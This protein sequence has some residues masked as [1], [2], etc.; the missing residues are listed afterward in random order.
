MKPA[1]RQVEFSLLIATLVMVSIGTAPA[2]FTH[3]G[4][5]NAPW[6]DPKFFPI[7]VWL[8]VPENAARY[9]AAGINTYVGLWDG[10]KTGQ[11]EALQQ[12]GMFVICGQ[13]IRALERRNE[14]TII[15]WHQPDEPD[16]ARRRGA[17][18][19]WGQ[20]TPPAEIIA[21]Y[22]RLKR[23][24]PSRPV[25]L[26]LGQ[27]VAWDGWYGR[28]SRNNRPEDYPEYVQGGD[29]LSFNIYPVNHDRPEI[30]GNLW[31][32][33]E[34]VKRLR[35]W[36]GESKPVWNCI[37]TTR[38]ETIGRK[39]TPAEVRAQVWM[40]LIHGARGLIYFVHQFTP[41]FVEAGLLADAEM[42]AAV[43][44]INREITELAPVLNS[45]A[46]TN[47]V[48]VRA[49]NSAA[50][51]ATLTKQHGQFTYVF[52][53]AMRPLSTEVEF[54]GAIFRNVTTVEVIGESRTR[55]IAQG[56]FT[57]TFAPYEV[58]LYRIETPPAH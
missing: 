46:V 19:G 14:S 20:P 54:A 5:T 31:I 22:E 28:G 45:P 7:G 9:R 1:R 58:H 3:P 23:A 44:T 56:M 42:L 35:Q 41:T 12:A 50:P 57:D 53:V 36:A 52:A 25:L 2:Q 8:Q 26:G 39:P 17:R 51:I 32:V 49:R 13:T 40:S 33:A 16:N 43:T 21:A 38:I 34:G 11:L 18:L 6:S 30:S 27:G 29:I 24:D 4:F 10:P 55:H 47:V 37:E 15:G 48:R